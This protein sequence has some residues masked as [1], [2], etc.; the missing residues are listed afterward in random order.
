MKTK[1]QYLGVVNSKSVLSW[2]WTQGPNLLA[3]ALL[4]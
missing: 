2:V 1:T 3:G 4:A